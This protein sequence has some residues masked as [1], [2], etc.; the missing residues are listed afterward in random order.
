LVRIVSAVTRQAGL[1]QA[2]ES[3][4][5]CPVTGL[6][7]AHVVRCYQ[8]GDVA[9]PATDVGVGVN[10][11]VVDRIMNEGGRIERHHLVLPAEVVTVALGAT[12]FVVGCVESNPPFDTG[13]ERRVASKTLLSRGPLLPQ[14]VA[15]GALPNAL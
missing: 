4:V 14:L 9:V 15:L 7:L 1:F 2:Q 13:L 5:E 6:E 12:L 10:Q 11:L 8:I 3:L